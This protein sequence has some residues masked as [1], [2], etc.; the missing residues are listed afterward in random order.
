MAFPVLDFHFLNTTRAAC[1]PLQREIQ[2]FLSM[3]T[4]WNCR[5]PQRHLPQQLQHWQ[6]RKQANRTKPSSENINRVLRFTCDTVH[7]ILHLSFQRKH[8]S[9]SEHINRVLRF[10]CDTVHFI[11]HLSFQRKHQSASEHINRVLRFTCDTV[12]FILHLSFQRKHQS[13]CF[14]LNAV[15][16]QNALLARRYLQRSQKSTISSKRVENLFRNMFIN[17]TCPYNCT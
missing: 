6:H 7:F 4:V 17:H 2:S 14:S 5:H 1:N 8:Q 16:Q 12:H 9:A 10:T 13:A 11:L 15:R 3:S